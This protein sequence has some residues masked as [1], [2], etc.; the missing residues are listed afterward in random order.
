MSA[1]HRDR[2]LHPDCSGDRLSEKGG[3][4]KGGLAGSLT[5]TVEDDQLAFGCDGRLFRE[6][7]LEAGLAPADDRVCAA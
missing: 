5:A 7:D 6:L 1:P 3:G 2:H 4:I